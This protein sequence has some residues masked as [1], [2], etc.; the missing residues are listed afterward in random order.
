MADNW[1]SNNLPW[2]SGGTSFGK[3][4]PVMIN[5]DL[6]YQADSDFLGEETGTVNCFLERVGIPL[7]AEHVD[8]SSVKLITRVWLV[9]EGTDGDT[10]DVYVGMQENNS[11]GPVNY[12]APVT[13]TIGT[14]EAIDVLVS[15]RFAALKFVATDIDPWTLVEYVIDFEVVGR[16]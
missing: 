10:I 3:A 16:H 5:S 4:L 14:T 1:N 8:P 12:L 9:I 15:G 7:V 13:Y 2:D 6:F 11:Q